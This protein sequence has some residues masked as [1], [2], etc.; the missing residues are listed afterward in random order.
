M[1]RSF[2]HSEASTVCFPMPRR[3]T[4]AWSLKH[5][6]PIQVCF[7]RDVAIIFAFRSLYSLFPNASKDDC[8][9]VAKRLSAHHVLANV[10][11]KINWMPHYISLYFISRLFVW[12]TSSLVEDAFTASD[13]DCIVLRQTFIRYNEQKTQ[14]NFFLLS[15]RWDRGWFA[16]RSVEVSLRRL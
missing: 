5:R 13:C 6:V 14:Y 2:L 15:M 12:W 3:K 16:L 4:V 1:L 8:N 9:V 11:R 7:L 10:Y